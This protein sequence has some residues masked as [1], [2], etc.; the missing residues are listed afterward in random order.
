MRLVG[1]G[2]IQRLFARADA[3]TILRRP[4]IRRFAADNGV[5]HQIIQSIWLIDLEDF[6]KAIAPKEFEGNLSM[7]RLRCIQTAV[8]EY[9]QAHDQQIDKHVVEKCMKSDEVFK[10]HHG[11]RWIINYD[12]LEPVIDG[13][14]NEKTG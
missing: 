10:Y 3:D 12:E 1:S 11:N 9:N 6:M 7:P 8:I 13:Y 14:L 2:D 4:N 5:R